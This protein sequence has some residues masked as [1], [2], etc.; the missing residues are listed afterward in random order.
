[1]RVA[2]LALALLPSAAFGEQ[3]LRLVKQARLST[4]Y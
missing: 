4:F 2:L 3:R 1:M